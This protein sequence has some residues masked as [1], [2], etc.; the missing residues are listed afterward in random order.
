MRCLYREGK[1]NTEEYRKVIKEARKTIGED[2][3]KHYEQEQK[4]SQKITKT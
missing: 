4:M 1:Y 2:L 3:E